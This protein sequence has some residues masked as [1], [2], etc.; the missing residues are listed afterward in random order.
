MQHKKDLTL[1]MGEGAMRQGMQVPSLRLVPSHR[2]WLRKLK[3]SGHS[4]LSAQYDMQREA[5]AQL[6]PTALAMAVAGRNRHLPCLG[7]SRAGIHKQLC[8]RVPPPMV[9]S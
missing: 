4:P 2:L 5:R 6:F 3:F 7:Q 9:S 1:K 8:Y